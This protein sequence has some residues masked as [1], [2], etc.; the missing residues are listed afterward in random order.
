MKEWAPTELAKRVGKAYAGFF[1]GKFYSVLLTHAGHYRGNH[2]HPNTQSTILLSGKAKYVQKIGDDLVAIPM[3]VGKQIDVEAGVPH[4]LLAEEETLT[5]SGGTGS[6]RKSP[7]RSWRLRGEN[8]VNK[9]HNPSLFSL[10][11]G[12]FRSKFSSKEE[13]SIFLSHY[14]C[15]FKSVMR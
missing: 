10:I 13:S 6:S 4:I 1:G 5:I 12:T 15:S 14:Q 9:L 2:I 11:L 3:E 7:T 8:T